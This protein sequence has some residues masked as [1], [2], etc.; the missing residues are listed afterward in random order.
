MAFTTNFGS[1]DYEDVLQNYS[2]TALQQAE[3]VANRPFTPYAGERVAGFDPLEAEGRDAALALAR[4]GVGMPQVQQAADV[5]ARA[6]GY[7]AGTYDPAL[8]AGSD[9]SQYM[10]PYM[11]QAIDPALRQI[12]EQQAMTL[13]GVSDAAARA[14]AFGGSRQ[15][16]LEAETLKGFG[17]QQADII[18]QAQQRAYEQ[19]VAQR[20]GDIGRLNEAQRT[21][22]A[23]RLSGLEAQMSG[24][25]ALS[26]VA[27]QLRGLGYSDAEVMRSLGQEGRAL[28]QARLEVPYQEFMREQA[29]PS[30]QL[31]ARLAPLG[32]GAQ[33]ASAA[34][35]VDEPSFLQQT[36]G[37]VGYLAN[38]AGGLG[39][40][41]IIG[42]GGSGSLFEF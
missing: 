1:G 25:T 10:S 6:A 42:R 14:G 20:T 38:L 24:A 22:E 29:F 5:A 27:N 40:A 11:E 23:M 9:L 16:V 39:K 4:E 8:M 30:E 19:A 21:N 31:S 17:Q 37:G 32:F 13:Q 3:D 28:E 7:Q 18:N 26:Q 41:G 35:T 2:K 34:P 36:L 12:R 15:G 33:V